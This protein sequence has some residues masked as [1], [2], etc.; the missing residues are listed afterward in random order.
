MPK[1]RTDA[2]DPFFTA[3]NKIAHYLDHTTTPVADA[4][5]ARQ[6]RYQQEDRTMCDEALLLVRDLIHATA[7]TLHDCDT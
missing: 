1:A 6:P 7:E 2:L 4:A 3:R 5:P